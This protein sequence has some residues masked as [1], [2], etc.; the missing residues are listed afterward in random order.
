[1]EKRRIAVVASTFG[2]G[3]A[4][5][6]TGNVLRRLPR[7]RYDVRLHFLHD[8]GIVGRDLL[9]DG[10]DGTERL[11]R[12]R[13]DVGGAVR[14]AR[15]FRS[16]VPGLVWCLD[17][18]D[19]MWLGRM[20]ALFTGVPAS[21]IASHSTGLVDARGRIR[22]SFRRRE[23]VLVEFMARIVAVSET[24]ARYLRDV[25]GLPAG[26]IVVIENGIDV[27]AWPVATPAR[28]RE[29]RTALGIDAADAVVTMVAA[30][31]PEKAH[32]VLLHAVEIL[33]ASGR[34]VRVL[35][36]GDG[37]L[38]ETLRRDAQRRGIADRVEFLGIRRDVARLLHAS[39]AVVLPSRAVV[40][41][42][43][44]SVLEAMASGVP[45]IASRVGSVPEVVVDGETGR[46]VAPGDAMELARV[47][48]ATL[49]DAM[50][51]GR[52]SREARRRVEARYSVDRTT[53]RYEQLFDELMTA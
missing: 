47:I 13:R 1:M 50:A 8:A 18:V 42:L 3:G 40:E 38:L 25:T 9:T 32:D 6:V 30:M 31:R 24:H 26:R 14:L 39:D 49:D 4:E 41:T 5:I 45:V 46:L 10:F 53:A 20:A 44:L 48:A 35:L 11:C 37:P 19:A 27:D 15:R 33:H 22:P 21:I 28:R 36:A 7:E 34:R 51:A 29:A 52:W 16:F 23:R 43:P 2:V 17:H 12:G